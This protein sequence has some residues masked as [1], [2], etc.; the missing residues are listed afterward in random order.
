MAKITVR[1]C[2]MFSRLDMVHQGQIVTLCRIP[3]DIRYFVQSSAL[4]AR[5]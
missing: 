1:F 3:Y 2:D 4:K 5:C